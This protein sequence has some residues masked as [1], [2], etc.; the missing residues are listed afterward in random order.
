M[1]AAVPNGTPKGKGKE[2]EKAQG[3]DDND[4]VNDPS[5]RDNHDL[6]ALYIVQQASLHYMLPVHNADLET[7]LRHGRRLH[8]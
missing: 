7:L 2:K 1:E 8:E 6:S 4:D 3:G 5:Y